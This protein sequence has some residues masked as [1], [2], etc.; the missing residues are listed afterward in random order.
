MWILWNKSVSKYLHSFPNG[1]WEC[2]L[3][4]FMRIWCCNY[5]IMHYWLSSNHVLTIIL[6]YDVHHVHESQSDDMDH[7]WSQNTLLIDITK[8]T[9]LNIISHNIYYY[10][11]S[12]WYILWCGN[13]TTLII[14][15]KNLISFH[16][17][18]IW[19]E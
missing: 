7:Q 18:A 5:R 2:D 14:P 17:N 3:F 12:P 9:F 11:L 6:S 13:A 1:K 16:I 10:H 8:M 19:P 4:L 15:K